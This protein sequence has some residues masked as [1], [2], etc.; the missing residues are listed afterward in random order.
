MKNRLTDLDINDPFYKANKDKIVH[1]ESPKDKEDE[2]GYPTAE[3]PCICTGIVN[4]SC[5]YH[6]DKNSPLKKYT[7]KF[8]EEIEAN[9]S[10]DKVEEH[11]CKGVCNDCFDD[12]FKGCPCPHSKVEPLQD[13]WKEKLKL[14][15]KISFEN[16][17]GTDPRTNIELFIE[18]LLTTQKAEIRK[19]VE[20]KRVEVR[21]D[22][23]ILE[24]QCTAY[25][26]AI[27]DILSEL[28]KL[29]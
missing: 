24:A 15:W 7:D 14:L 26:Q 18:N 21:Y 28:D 2:E 25:N 23:P 3:Y 12:G 27:Y 22:N 16:E 13:E 20:G 11:D 1:V 8:F 19:M 5:P 10:K 9:L 6:M 17:K 29:K 4:F